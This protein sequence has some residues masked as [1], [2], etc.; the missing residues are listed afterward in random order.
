MK[1]AYDDLLV[2]T[3]AEY[4]VCADLMLMGYP[5]FRADQGASYD[6]ACDADGRLIR[7]Q[8]KSTRTARR[9]PQERQQ[10]IVGYTW[11]FRQGKRGVRKYDVSALDAVA[12]VA[13]DTQQIAYVAAAK[14]PITFQIPVNGHTRSTRTFDDF[15]FNEILEC[16]L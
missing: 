10:H 15:N 11:S 7:L 6:I 4:L 3:A 5:A 2:G 13:L 16:A 14:C 8:V 12:F 9:Y 1:F